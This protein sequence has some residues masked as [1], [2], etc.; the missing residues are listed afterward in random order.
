[1]SDSVFFD[2]NSLIY[3]FSPLENRKQDLATAFL[4]EAVLR[5]NG[6]ISYQVVQ[7]VLNVGLKGGKT[8][9]TMPEAALLVES[10]S[11]D[12]Q[13]VPWS[14]ALVKQA[15]N[16]RDRFRFHWYDCLIVAA[17]LEAKCDVLYTE[18][19]QHGQRI[20]GLTVVNPFL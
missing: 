9:L 18:D 4:R 16:I 11:I 6:V 20:E 2:S 15:L 17:A 14:L 13:I 3:R 19:L 10:F 1:M 7:E 12:F 8:L 5:Q